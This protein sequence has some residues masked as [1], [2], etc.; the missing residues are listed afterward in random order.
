M[1][2]LVAAVPGEDSA[3]TLAPARVPVRPRDEAE[4]AN[5]EDLDERNNGWI[6]VARC[7]G[8]KK[9]LRRRKRLD[10]R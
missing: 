4:A 7:R 9:S 5:D 2:W 6:L 3:C 10:L 1:A 8:G